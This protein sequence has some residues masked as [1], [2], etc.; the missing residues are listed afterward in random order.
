MMKKILIFLVLSITCFGQINKISTIKDLYA[1][2][3]EKTD[4]NGEKRDREYTIKYIAPDYL[5]KEVIL[6]KIN[7][8]EIYQYENQKRY[9]YIPLFNEVTEESG[10]DEFDNFLT[11]I[12][13]LKRK[14]STDK[15]FSQNYYNKKIVELKFQ[16]TYSIKIKKFKEVD[17]YLLPIDL[18]IY[19]GKVKISN[20]KL[21][22][23]KVNSSLKKEEL[24]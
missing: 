6:P 14:D 22:D 20:I 19:D 4:I 2:V 11:I 7:K 18:E 8:G 15:V 3:V 17:N 1:K 12:N 10:K 23:I 24:K 9:V 13:E 21:E 5:R 16:N